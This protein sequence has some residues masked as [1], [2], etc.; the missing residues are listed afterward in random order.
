MDAL[1]ALVRYNLNED[2]QEQG[3]GL[4]VQ[5][6][7]GQQAQEGRLEQVRQIRRIQVQIQRQG[8]IRLQGQ[9]QG[10]LQDANKKGD[11]V[12][13]AT[14]RPIRDLLDLSDPSGS[15]VPLPL[16]ID[17]I[18]HKSPFINFCETCEELVCSQCTVFGPHNNHV[19]PSRFSC[20]AS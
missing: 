17:C 3:Q 19:S 11:Q 10:G 13:E 9:G 8:E 1:V 7:Q 20:T 14:R 15:C 6:E 2:G 18:H 16:L 5:E 12:Q 4:Q